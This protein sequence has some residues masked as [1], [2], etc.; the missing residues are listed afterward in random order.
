MSPEANIG[1][2]IAS[3]SPNMTLETPPSEDIRKVKMR[4]LPNVAAS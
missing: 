3:F 4:K 1:E 2:R